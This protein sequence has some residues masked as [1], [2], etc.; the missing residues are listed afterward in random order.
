[1][2]AK[3]KMKPL[4]LLLVAALFA[5]A[6][7]AQ[8]QDQTPP[9]RRAFNE[10]LGWIGVA[11]MMG[12]ALVMVPWKTEVGAEDVN[13]F[14]QDVCWIDDPLHRRFDVQRGMCA[15]TTPRIKAG[16]ITMGIGGAIAVLGFH[17]VTV[18]PQIGPQVLS[19]RVSVRW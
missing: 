12:G 6:V 14:G 15:T 16:L 2:M 8:A 3:T 10:K 19:A 13:L 17:K 1:M 9:V 5:G 11:T 7:P 18:E 4:A